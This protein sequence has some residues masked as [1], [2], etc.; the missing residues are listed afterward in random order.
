MTKYNL[1][2]SVGIATIKPSTSVRNLGIKF[3]SKMLMKDQVTNRCK[4]THYNLKNICAIRKVL[5]DDSAVK[6]DYCNSPSNIL[7]IADMG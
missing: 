6:L 7:H 4:S 5:T 1:E 3:D 2:L